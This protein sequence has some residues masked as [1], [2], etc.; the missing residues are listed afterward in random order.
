VLAN[1]GRIADARARDELNLRRVLSSHPRL[2]DPQ[3][4][5]L[6]ILVEWDRPR[7]RTWVPG[8][9]QVWFIT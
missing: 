5:P 9:E 8:G 4:E 7:T 3:A 1:S 6:L 2:D